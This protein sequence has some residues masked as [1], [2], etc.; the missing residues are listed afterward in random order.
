MFDWLTNLFGTAEDAW[1]S[2]V[3]RFVAVSQELDTALQQ[4]LA[5]RGLAEQLGDLDNWNAYQDRILYTR[6]AI[7]D[8]SDR[9]RS[10]S[11]W[12]QQTFGQSALGF[13]PIVPLAVITGS[14]S[15]MVSL[16]YAVNSYNTNIRQ[17]WEYI[18]GNPNLTPQQVQEVLE[19]EGSGLG[20][21]NS[22]TWLV[23]GGVAL[24]MLPQVL[25][26]MKGK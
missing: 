14:I 13:I 23:I 10:G 4:H 20:I 25:T 2:A 24:L 11:Q 3:A 8:I 22:V 1:Q 21:G 26:A 7:I 6:Q 18:N 16:I 9:L 12:F 5:I 19:S 17:K 15:A